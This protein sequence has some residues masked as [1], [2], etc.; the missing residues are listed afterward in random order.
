M[1]LVAIAPGADRQKAL[2]A[3]VNG[4]MGVMGANGT[5]VVRLYATAKLGLRV[6]THRAGTTVWRATF[7]FPRPGKWELV[8]PNW[9]APGYA[10]PLPAARFV[11]VH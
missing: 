4:T 2:D 11:T 7:R 10:S 3:L 9:C 8:V 1:R 5:I 6:A